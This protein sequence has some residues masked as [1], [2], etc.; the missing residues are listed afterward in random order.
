[1]VKEVRSGSVGDRSLRPWPGVYP[2][3]MST[4]ATADI[5]RR[6]SFYRNLSPLLFKYRTATHK[7]ATACLRAG[8]LTA[9]NPISLNDP[10]DSKPHSLLRNA[11]E[12][13]R[14]L[15]LKRIKRTKFLCFTRQLDGTQNDI[16]RW[17]HYAEGHRGYCLMIS[18]PWLSANAKP[19]EYPPE[20]RIPDAS[21]SDYSSFWQQVGFFKAPV[22][23]YE[24]ES[25]VILPIKS[26][27]AYILPKGSV[28]GIVFG[29]WSRPKERVKLMK[30]VFK[31]SPQCEVF[32]ARVLP[33]QWGIVY[34]W[35]NPR[36][37]VRSIRARVTNGGVAERRAA[38]RV[39][40]CD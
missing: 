4:N 9:P 28:W 2:A 34:D 26:Q 5:E 8:R 32:L 10:F 19:V 21:P 16:L 23:S 14:R 24:D 20:Y 3:R 25:R 18:D 7:E 30:A 31:H 15:L 37:D 13:E 27:R 12:D 36:G 40:S 39:H 33:H 35:I 17:S 1:M 29:C 22:W 38:L 11:S 6:L